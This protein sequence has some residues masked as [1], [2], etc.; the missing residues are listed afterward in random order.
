VFEEDVE[1]TIRDDRDKCGDCKFYLMIDSGYGYCCRFP[2]R[3]ENTSNRWSPKWAIHYQSVEWCRIA[4]GEFSKSP[5]KAL[6][7]GGYRKRQEV[8]PWKQ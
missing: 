1:F 5:I 6:R 8:K 2:P 3:T 7:R 4:C